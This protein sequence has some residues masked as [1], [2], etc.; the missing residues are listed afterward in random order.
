MNYS[1]KC[2]L[3]TWSK[4]TQTKPTCGEQ[5]RTICSELACPELVEEVEPILFGL[6]RYGFLLRTMVCVG[7]RPVRDFSH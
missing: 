1:E 7:P 2:K 3:D 6:K 5:S 4:R